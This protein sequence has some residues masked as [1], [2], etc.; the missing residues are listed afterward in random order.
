MKPPSVVV[1]QP[2]RNASRATS[3]SD[4]SV[5][6]ISSYILNLPELPEYR[7]GAIALAASC[8]I[9]NLANQ[10]AAGGVDILA[11]VVRTVTTKP[12]STS[13]CQNRLTALPL[14]RW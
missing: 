12:A 1:T 14:G 3:A 9:D 6:V 13:T 11:T 2:A 7:R 8:A 10:L 4:L 5:S